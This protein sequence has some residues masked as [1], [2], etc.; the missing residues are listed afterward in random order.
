[1]LKLNTAFAERI[2][3]CYTTPRGQTPKKAIGRCLTLGIVQDQLTQGY[4]HS[5][6]DKRRNA[7]AEQHDSVRY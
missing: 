5:H 2:R 7:F 4:E 6:T 3:A 1:M